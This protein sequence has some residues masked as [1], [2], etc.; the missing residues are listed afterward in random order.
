MLRRLEW[1]GFRMAGIALLLLLLPVKRNRDCTPVGNEQ[2][3]IRLVAVVDS[4]YWNTLLD[5][6][7]PSNSYPGIYVSPRPHVGF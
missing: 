6:Q 3:M 2:H 4:S 1:I 5:L 7:E